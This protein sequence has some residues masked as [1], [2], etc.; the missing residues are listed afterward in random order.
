MKKYTKTYLDSF[1]LDETDYIPCEACMTSQAVDIHHI[2]SRKRDKELFNDVRNLMAVCRD[3]H[4]RYGEVNDFI[5][6]LFKIHYTIMKLKGVYAEKD[7]FD[8]IIEKYDN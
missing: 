8:K 1:R 7:W 2:I 6:M 5:P 4:Q 3:C